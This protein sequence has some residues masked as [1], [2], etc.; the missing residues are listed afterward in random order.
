ME[1]SFDPTAETN[2]EAT[3]AMRIITPAAL[4]LLACTW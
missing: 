1:S 2:D 4:R 3:S